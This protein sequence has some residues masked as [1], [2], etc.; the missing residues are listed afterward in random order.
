MRLRRPLVQRVVS[1]TA[2]VE[3][4][5]SSRRQRRTRQSPDHFVE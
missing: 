2:G 5:G 3:E 4:R 1:E